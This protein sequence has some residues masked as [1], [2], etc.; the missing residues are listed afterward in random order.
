V[1]KR[2]ALLWIQNREHDLPA[3]LEGRTGWTIEGAR[4]TVAGVP[5]GP[6]RIEW[7]DTRRGNVVRTT[8][9]RTSADGLSLV[10]PPL[11][12]DIG[13]KVRW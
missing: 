4:L 11:A 2:E 7:W 12:T 10:L 1:G 13:C 6:C 3:V 9:E 5:V 8:Q